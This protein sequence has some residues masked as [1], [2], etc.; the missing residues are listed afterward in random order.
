[1]IKFINYHNNIFISLCFSIILF[2]IIDKMIFYFG[3]KL[4]N[5]K[6]SIINQIIKNDPKMI[7]L[8]SSTSKYSINPDFFDIKTFNSSSNGNGI[9]YSNLLLSNIPLNSIDYI[10]LGIDPANF[11]IKA[12]YENY[13]EMLLFSKHPDYF[14]DLLRETGVVNNITENLQSYKVRSLPKVIKNYYLDSSH[15]GYS[16]LYGNLISSKSNK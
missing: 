8:G 5:E 4:F 7:V 3:S 16:P 10:F 1:M 11:A 14:E 9:I 2:I 13:G 15:N 6:Y 12:N